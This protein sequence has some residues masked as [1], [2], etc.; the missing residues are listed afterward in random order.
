[1]RHMRVT[2]GMAVSGSTHKRTLAQIG[3][4]HGYK[5]HRFS[6]APSRRIPY[7]SLDELSAVVGFDAGLKA[8]F[9]PLLMKLEMT[10]KNLALL[11]LL[12][13]A[14][15]SV[16]T[17]VYSRLLPGTKKNGLRGKLEVVHAGD[18]VLL[19]R[20]ARGDRIVRH[21]YDIPGQA[22]PLWALLEVITLGHFGKLLEQLSADAVV[23][24][25]SSWGLRRT[26][27]DLVPHLV[28]AMTDLR[29][30]VAH[31][32]VVFDTRFASARIRKRVAGLLARELG[33]AQTLSVDFTTI[34]DYLALAVYLSVRLRFPKREVYRAIKYHS[35][36]TDDLRDRVPARVF[37]M[38]VHTDNRANV[39][40]LEAWVRAS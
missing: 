23:L 19:D 29:N 16:L 40:G 22:V 18:A 36:L 26:D 12:G 27:A 39:A 13:A 34:T 31:N 6:G 35:A 3:Y 7:G 30:A 8:L 5:G 25:A 9:Y 32:G 1:M 2:T 15:S 14:D 17:D 28:F 4:F 21:Y 20:Y 24:V 33:F 10:M 38:I 37:D 11:Q